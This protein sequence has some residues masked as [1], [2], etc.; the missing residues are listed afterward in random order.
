MNKPAHRVYQ[1]GPFRLDT[2]ERL[3]QRDGKTIPL[4]PKMFATLLV[5]IERQGRLVEKEALMKE[6]WPD[7]VVEEGARC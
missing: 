7:T 4:N 6:V 3:L 2:A 5:L 1:F